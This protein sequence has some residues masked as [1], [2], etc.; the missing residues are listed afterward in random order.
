[1]TTVGVKPMTF[2]ILHVYGKPLAKLLGLN[3]KRNECACITIINHLK[4]EVKGIS[5][6]VQRNTGILRFAKAIR[7][8]KTVRK[9]KIRESKMIFPLLY[10]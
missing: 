3:L 7:S 10:M 5:D 6:D 1:V 9:V 8:V 2:C 4:T